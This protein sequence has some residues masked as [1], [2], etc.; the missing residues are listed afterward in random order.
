MKGAFLVWGVIIC[1]LGDAPWW[2][3]LLVLTIATVLA[4][5]E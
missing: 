2:G 3:Y 4:S 1:L 5:D